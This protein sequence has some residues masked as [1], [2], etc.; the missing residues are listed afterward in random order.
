MYPEADYRRSWSL[1]NNNFIS[2]QH[3]FVI[4]FPLTSPEG[5]SAQHELAISKAV[6]RFQPSDACWYACRS[7]RWA[8]SLRQRFFGLYQNVLRIILTT[9]ASLGTEAKEAPLQRLVSFFW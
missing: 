8:S 6:Y 5:D 3:A 4:L 7:G 1:T 9:Y 2:K